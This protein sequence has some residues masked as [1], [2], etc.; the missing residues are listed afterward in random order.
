MAHGACQPGRGADGHDDAARPARDQDR[1]AE[2]RQA[3]RQ[4][5][6]DQP[7]QAESVQS[8]DAPQ[9]QLGGEARRGRTEGDAEPSCRDR[10][11]RGFAGPAV[12]ATS[13]QHERTDRRIEERG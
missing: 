4:I 13:E 11:R 8:G 12:R 9:E 10:R 7:H 2:Q 3:D 6:V 1:D 5:E